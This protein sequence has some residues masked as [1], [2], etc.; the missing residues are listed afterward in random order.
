MAA[1]IGIKIAVE[2][3][4]NPE[5]AKKIIKTVVIV[6]VILLALPAITMMGIRALLGEGIITNEFKIEESELYQAVYPVYEDYVTK[7][8]ES[9]KEQAEKIVEENTITETWEETVTDPETGEITV[10][11]K[12]RE[13]CTVDVYVICN[14]M[15]FSY[16]LSYLS[17]KNEDVVNSKKYQLNTAEVTDFLARIQE[18]KIQHL[19]S[20]YFIYNQYMTL[21][22]IAQ[23]TCGTDETDKEYF[24]VLYQNYKNFL[25]DVIESENYH[26]GG[27]DEAYKDDIQMSEN[28]MN[29]PQMYQHTG[30]W[31]NHPYG[32]GTIK[33]SGCALVCLAMVTS[34]LQ[35]NI[36]TPLDIVEFTGNKYY[37]SGAG[38]TWSIFPAVASHYG[39]NC[40]NLG[41]GSNAIINAL[42]SGHPVIASMGPGTFTKGGHFIVLKGI[43]EDGRIL[44]NDPN[45][46]NR[47]NHNNREFSMNLILA[48]GKN[49]WSFY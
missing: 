35:D 34:Y 49:F 48:E 32:N 45:D 22:E 29:I 16:L 37:Q 5:G 36:T 23:I 42:E 27:A 33:S 21:E 20:N 9:M 13:V 7:Q 44:V 25:E 4:R 47:K 40:T 28:E 18:V 10:T 11:T 39:F 2:I 46:S 43:T 17:I 19:G 6:L 41:K 30:A 8:T 14:H 3:A 12:S 31:S 24:N 1:H 38:S 26:F 15:D